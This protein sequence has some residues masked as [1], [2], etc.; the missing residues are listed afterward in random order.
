MDFVVLCASVPLWFAYLRGVKL[1]R[2]GTANEIFLA[3]TQPWP[4]MLA[5]PK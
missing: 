3:S 4:K 2:T 1:R 5:D